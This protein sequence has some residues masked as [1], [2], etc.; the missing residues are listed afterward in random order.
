MRISIL[1]IIVSI[2]IV[3][4]SYSQNHCNIKNHYNDFILIKKLALGKDNILMKRVVKAKKA[5][6]F[7]ELVNN[8]TM[9]VNYLLTNFSSSSNDKKLLK[10]ADSVTLKKSYFSELKKDSLFNSLIIE[11]SNK[12]INRKVAKDSIST[13]DL[14]NI[15][16]KYFSI[17]KLNEKGDYAGKVCA[18]LNDIKKTE[19]DRKP[20]VEAF[21]F[22][23]ILKHYNGA[24]FS[25]QKEFIKSIKEL[26]KLN[27][28]IDKREKLLRAQGAMFI[29][30][31]N[32]DNLKEMLKTEY[33]RQKEYLPFVLINE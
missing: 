30:M 19:R 4:H 23:S 14:L 8:N 24:K 5:S 26:Y 28:G 6:C 9:F 11:L 33:E 16:V 25:M 27:L 29:L 10:L 21:S 2:S 20:F 22:S 32:N 3:I 13:G 17:K 12:T 31:R 1:T 7:S 18:G 15:A